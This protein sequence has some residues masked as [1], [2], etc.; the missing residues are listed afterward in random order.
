[1]TTLP[2]RPKDLLPSGPLPARVWLSAKEAA[3]YLGCSE[4]QFIRI[5]DAHG[6]ASSKPSDGLRRWHVEDIDAMMDK[7]KQE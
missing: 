2:A 5:A 1:M 6:V 4:R 3:G 7:A